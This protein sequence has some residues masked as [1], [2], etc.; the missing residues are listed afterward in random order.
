MELIKSAIA[1]LYRAE[2][3]AC[4]GLAYRLSGQLE[5]AV[6]AYN[7]SLRREREQT[8]ISPSYGRT[9]FGLFNSGQT[10]RHLPTSLSEVTIFINVALA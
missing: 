5:A 1:P 2:L 10:V 4:L 6:S 7:R 3:L 8:G 9:R